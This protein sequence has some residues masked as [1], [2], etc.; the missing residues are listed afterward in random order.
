M[1]LVLRIAATSSM[2]LVASC[3]SRPSSW[4]RGVDTTVTP[5]GLANGVVLVDDVNH[6]AV[7][8]TSTPDHSLQ[9]QRFTI[10]HNFA[11]ATPLP[12]LSAL[13]LLSTGDGPGAGNE[14]PSLTELQIA[15]GG[16]VT[17]TRFWM[18][19]PVANLVVDPQLRYA[20]G[21]QG[22]TSR[23]S[24]AAQPNQVVFTNP[25]EIV[26]FDLTM[27]PFDPSQPAGR[28]NVP[29]PV[30]RTLQS[31]GSSPQRLTFTPEMNLPPGSATA[32]K[33]RLVVVETKAEVTIVDLERAFQMPPS[34]DITV[35][36]SSGTSASS[37]TP[38]GLAVDT[39]NPDDGLLAERTDDH[40]VYTIQLV[41]PPPL[42]PGHTR[43]ANAND[44]TASP[45]LT[46]V[47]GTPSDIAFVSTGSEVRIAALVPNIGQAVLLRPDGS[48]V[49]SVVL[50]SSFSNMSIVTNLVAPATTPMTGSIPADVALLWGASRGAAGVALW[51]LGSA[52][53][54]PYRSVDPL[55]VTDSIT[56]VIDVP[57]S[58]LKLLTTPQ[59]STNALYV[60][61]L[62]HRTPSPIDSTG[63]SPY[64]SMAPDGGR[65]WL[66]I[67]SE[68][69]VA[70]ID[71]G[72]VGET[73]TLNPTP[74]RTTSAISSV[75]DIAACP[76]AMTDPKMCPRSL[77]ALHA[78]GTFG[79]TVF[80]AR[81]PQSTKPQEDVGLLL[82]GP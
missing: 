49:T 39:T 59:G 24:L 27:K 4:D 57:N 13:L 7:A 8:L 64:I 54:Q 71:L 37:V 29:N 11:S 62:A 1:T 42:A 70:S 22:G 51:S 63:G 60:L 5:Y 34:V 52:V 74:V 80:D 44:F 78:Q 30:S 73:A 61:D 38:A 82:E 12:D 41:A 58:A 66:Y 47:G 10:G 32:K 15:Q 76:S 6:E 50:P 56:S 67:P 20:I 81:A 25:N 68:Q 46:D 77:V 35:R 36:L 65:F 48:D 75:F 17:S 14:Q 55:T 43:P 28:T 19:Q 33:R 69:D 45:T 21:Y 16:K 72:T 26:L 40:N 23:Q 31:Y 9:T 3:G 79:A 2:C 18:T 53:G